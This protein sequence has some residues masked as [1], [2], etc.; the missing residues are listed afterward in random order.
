MV[1]IGRLIC[2]TERRR[3]GPSASDA[4]HAGVCPGR[5]QFSDGRG[6]AGD[7]A[8]RRDLDRQL[9]GTPPRKHRPAQHP[10]GPAGQKYGTAGQR[11]G[12]R[13]DVE[14]LSGA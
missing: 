7:A 4:A 1:L 12:D 14:Q 11:H 9:P 8:Q 2:D 5:R 10:E 6:N 13:G 3:P